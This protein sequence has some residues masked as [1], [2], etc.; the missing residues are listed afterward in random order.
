MRLLESA[1]SAS[2]CCFRQPHSKDHPV[3]FLTCSPPLTVGPLHR[4]V[5]HIAE[6]LDHFAGVQL[7]GPIH[8]ET[9]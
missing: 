4:K 7:T 6:I 8:K 1:K 3:S 5:A 9:K 2:L